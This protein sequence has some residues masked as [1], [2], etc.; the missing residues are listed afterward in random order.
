MGTF[1]PVPNRIGNVIAVSSSNIFAT[2]PASIPAGAGYRVRVV[3]NSPVV[4][5]NSTAPFSI[6]NALPPPSVFGDGV[7]H[8]YAFRDPSLSD[9]AGYFVEPSLSFDRTFASLTAPSDVAGFQGCFPPMQPTNYSVSY[10]RTNFSCGLYQFDL[11][12][13]DDECELRIDG[14]LVFSRGE[15]CPARP[16]IWQG[17]LGPNSQVEF[18]W[19]Q[20]VG[21]SRGAL[22]VQLVPF[23]LIAPTSAQICPGGSTPIQVTAP[24]PL[25]YTWAPATG[26]SATTGSTVV[27]S[28]AATTTY[29]VT[30][31]DPTTGCIAATANVQVQVGGPLLGL[32]VSPSASICPGGST[33]LLAS[34]GGNYTWS[35]ATGLSATTGNLVVAS[36]TTTTIYTVT[37]TDGCNPP[38]AANVTVTVGPPTTPANFGPGQWNVFCYTDPNWTNF[39]GYYIEP[40]NGPNLDFDSRTRWDPLTSPDRATG[41][42]GCA[43]PQ[44]GHSVSYR[45]TNFVPCGLVYQLDLTDVQDNVEVWLNGTRRFQSGLGSHP[46]VWRGLLGF[47]SQLDIRWQGFVNQSFVAARFRTISAV[48]APVVRICPTENYLLSAV[49]VPGASYEW[50]L[51]VGGPVIANTREFL[52]SPTSTQVYEL[53]LFSPEAGCNLTTTIQVI[54]DAAPA[55]VP[56]FPSAGASLSLCPGQSIVL[57][58]GGTGNASDFVWSPA[59]GLNTTVG[60]TVIASPSVPTTYTVTQTAS[61]ACTGGA[62]TG[63]V[64]VTVGPGNNP[65]DF[66]VNEWLA[67]TYFLGQYAGYY[68]D[69][70]VSIRSQDSWSP[71]GSPSDAAGYLG[72]PVPTDNHR[73]IYKRRGF[74][75]GYYR[76]AIPSYSARNA[77]V[78]L[79]VNGGALLTFGFAPA[80]PHNNLWEGFLNANSTIEFSWDATV[81]DSF[82]DLAVTNVGQEINF[83]ANQVTICSNPMGTSST[84]TAGWPAIPGAT[85]AWSVADPGLLT[86]RATTGS[87]ISVTPIAAGSTLITAV[88]TDPVSNCT[89]TRTFPAIISTTATYGLVPGN[90]TICRGDSVRVGLTGGARYVW[91]SVPPG[92]PGLQLLSFAG[93]QANVF[94][95]TTTTYTVTAING[96]ESRD[97]VFTVTVQQPVVPGNVWGTGKWMAM[98]YDG[99]DINEANNRYRGYFEIGDGSPLDKLSFKTSDY[100]PVASVPSQVIGY[101]GCDVVND[102]HAVVYRR[103]NFECGIYTIGIDQLIGEWVLIIDGFQ[104]ASSG[105]GSFPNLWTGVLTSASQVQ[106]SY[107]SRVG[108]SYFSLLVGI[109][110]LGVS[111]TST[112]W[113]GAVDTNWYNPLNW[114]LEVPT[115][116]INA[117]IALS[118][119]RPQPVIDPANNGGIGLA[120]TRNLS[121]ATNAS[122]TMVGNATLAVHGDWTNNGG[123]LIANPNTSVVLT[124]NTPSTLG[125]TTATQFYNLRLQKT[126]PTATVTLGNDPLVTNNLTLDNTGLRLNGARLTLDNPAPTALTRL[127]NGYIQSET[128][129]AVNPSYLCWNIGTNT[130]MYEFPF[131]VTGAAGDYIPVTLHKLD[132]ARGD[133]CISTR[134]TGPD[135]LPLAAGVVGWDVPAEV[136]IDRWWQVL[137]NGGIPADTLLNQGYNVTLRYAESENTLPAGMNTQPLKIQKTNNNFVWQ[138]PPEQDFAAGITSGVGSNTV[139]QIRQGGAFVL[140]TEDLFILPVDLVSFSARLLEGR[141]VVEWK[142]SRERNFAHFVVERSPDGAHFQPLAQLKGQGQASR[143]QFLDHNPL[144][145]LAYYR[146]KMV[147]HD[148]TTA[149]SKIMAIMN[150][151]EGPARME[152][153]PNPSLATEVSIFVQADPQARLKLQIC[154]LSGRLLAEAWAETDRNGRLLYALHP[155]VK[156]ASGMYYCWAVVNGRTLQTKVMVK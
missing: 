130:G 138:N 89:L 155:T 74:P 113:T 56:I 88:L 15:C 112:I 41:Y 72:C 126:A 57:T 140:L 8:A 78:T 62:R 22:N 129:A 30:G 21:D 109:A 2:V 144:V 119:T 128:N 145:G 44:D 134:R 18:R 64:T 37:S 99:V 90:V 125:G 66:G 76:I 26:L 92:N 150:Q 29:T 40:N 105:S 83:V 39:A 35:P 25:T 46:N 81:F 136:I 20:R 55:P 100:Y 12:Y 102:N 117:G 16:N 75:C 94:P 149:Y 86:L 116:T 58:A 151:A 106:L 124:G 9:Y 67:H 137:L 73:V 148:G 120:S 127:G 104:I 54:V 53:F 108:D 77:Q 5:S 48:A 114:C 27:A 65:T 118:G 132:A 139:R 121:L 141:V 59:T 28:P 13:N 131:G 23:A 63:T 34:G 45:R 115:S 91:N 152:A 52:V 93:D 6:T 123:N 11:V 154:D 122:L 49:E 24:R 80:P 19:R 7:W 103:T 60:Q 96:C 43:V 50:R 3:A 107:I 47:T 95:S 14:N 82:A 42:V 32:N 51:G 38:Q 142:T 153:R 1:P 133:F 31:T 17:F 79:R 101:Q 98:G 71:G 156:L 70:D 146:L 143:Y 4:V 84:L 135:N 87:T 69:S 10:R 36:P 147:D 68:R 97:Q 110:Q 111:G 85:F 33:R 61:A